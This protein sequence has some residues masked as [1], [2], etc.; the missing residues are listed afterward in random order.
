MRT[1][2]IRSA[3]PLATM[4]ILWGLLQTAAPA[5]AE[6]VLDRALSGLHQINRKSCAIIKIEFNFRIRYG[7]HIPLGHGSEL[8]ISIRA[9]DPDQAASLNLIRREALRAPADRLSGIK[10]IEFVTDDPGG[11]ALRI[12]FDRPMAFNVAPGA[13]AQ[14]VIIAVAG[15]TPQ[16]GCQPEFPA[17]SGNGW[18]TTVLTDSPAAGA[19]AA[20]FIPHTRGAGTASAVQV[21]HA[22]ALM[23]ETR[24]AMR[25]GNF[26]GA[27]QKLG[28]VLSLP[29]TPSAPEAQELLGVVRQKTGMQAQARREYEVYLTLYP[30]G[31]AADRVRQRLAGLET[32]EERAVGQLRKPKGGRGPANGEATWTVSGS[33]SQFYIRDDSF[34]TLR[35]PSLAP[36]LNSNNDDHRVHRNTLLSSFDVIAAWNDAATKSKFRFSGTEEHDFSNRKDDFIAVAALNLETTYRDLDLTTRI[37]RQTRNTGGVLGRF[38]GGVVSWQANPFLKFNTVVGSPVARRQD[39][40]FKDEKLFY[41][42]SV[43]IG[44]YLGGLETSLFAIE[45]RD[46][47]LL[48]RQAIGAELRYLQPDKSFFATIDYDVHFGALNAAV[49]SGSWTLADKSTL[50]GS[51]DYRKAPY[52]SAWNALQGQPFLRLYDLLKIATKDQIDQLAIDRTATYQSVM[53]GYSLP[54]SEKVRLTVDATVADVSGTIASGGVA[55][56]LAPGTD[57][58]ASAQL[59]ATSV[60]QEGDMYAAGLRYAH[61]SDSNLY[62][63]DFSA[64]YPISEALKVTP[65]LRLGYRTG[66]G[67]DLTEYSALPSVLF[68]YYVSRDFSFEVEGGASWTQLQQNGA[69]ETT[70]E[71]FVT[72]GFRYDFS[73]DGTVKCDRPQW[74]VGCK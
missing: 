30:Q 61:F 74:G 59:M 23:D 1:A 27:A 60:F 25:Q 32:A 38:D 67:I 37:G 22:A 47:S 51:A 41:G 70:T 26:E 5:V 18:N 48:D 52:L 62:V 42:A 50:Y 69:R 56:T 65:R 39:S 43:D 72:A 63:A 13:D 28:K 54:L 8:S 44:P 36:D 9:V 31:E 64:R 34:R 3:K 45:Q 40:P 55:A 12:S 71:L 2:K 33:A 7:G 6:P 16:A 66:D 73:A 4:L 58:Y 24:A 17:S 35:D 15:K 10:A 11:P 53:L 49:F 68:N 46:R 20:A 19:A 14:S 57:I 21:Q 29:E